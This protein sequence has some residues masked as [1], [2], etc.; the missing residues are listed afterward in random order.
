MEQNE[1]VGVPVLRQAQEP[2]RIKLFRGD[3]SWI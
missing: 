3:L 2:L 1:M